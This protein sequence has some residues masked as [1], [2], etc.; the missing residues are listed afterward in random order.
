MKISAQHLFC[1]PSRAWT[2]A[3]RTLRLFPSWASQTHAPAARLMAFL[4]CNALLFAVAR[5]APDYTFSTLA[6]QVGTNGSANGTGSNAQFNQPGGV[7]VD[8]TGT[9]YVADSANHTIRAIS[10]DGVV[11]TLAG[12]AGISGTNDDTGVAAR[13]SFPQGLA[14]D[15][16]GNLFVADTGNN[17][18]RKITPDGIVTT[19]AG[20]AG[21]SGTNDGPGLAAHFLHP[22]AVTVDGAGNVFV[23]DTGNYTIRKITPAGDVTTLAGRPGVHGRTDGPGNLARFFSP[24][25][26]VAD[27]AGNL[28]VADTDNSVIRQIDLA[29]NVGTFAGSTEPGQLDGHGTAAS[30]SQPYGL[31]RDGAGNLY[32]ADTGNG[33]IRRI[34]PAADVA[35][36]PGA[37]NI[38]GGVLPQA[39]AVDL[40]GNVLMADTGNHVIRRGVLTGGAL[41]IVQANIALGGTV[42]GSG[43]YPLGSNVLIT[44]TASNAWVFSAWNDS[45]TNN[46]RMVV[47]PSGGAT[48]TA[49]FSPLGTVTV[50]ANPSTGGSVAGGGQYIMGSNA[51]VTATASN[52]WQFLNWNG[53]MTNNPWSF[54]VSSSSQSCTANFAR[55]S[56]VAVLAS[57]TNGGSVAG[58]GAYVVGS[59]AVLTA[60]ASNNWLFIKWTDGV[61]NNP[62]VIVVPANNSTYTANFAATAAINVGANTNDGGSVTGGGVYLVGSND[63]LTATASNGW[64][65]IRWSDGPTNSPRTVVVGGAGASYTAIFAPT[66]V[67]SVQA[68]PANGG[69][70]TGGGTYVAGS[71]AVLS[72]TASNLWRFISWDDSVTNTPRT[73]VV[74]S[75]GATYTANFSPLGTVTVLANPTS[76]GRVNGGGQYLVG[77]NATVTAT[78]SNNWVFMNWNG[79]VTNNPWLFSVASGSATCT[80]NFAKLSTVTVVASPAGVGSVTGGGSYL[81]GSNVTLTATAA[82]GWL[83]AQWNDGLTNAG[84]VIVVPVANVTYTA[85]FVRGIG[86]AVDATNLTWTTGG[87]ANW[88]VQTATTRDGVAALRSGALSAGQQ[89]WFQTTTNGP[90]SLQFW[91]KV[92]SA[93]TS[94]LQFYINTQLVSQ[95]SG[96]VDWNQVVTFIGT[97]NQVT[98]KWVYTKNTSAVSGSD[99]GWVDQVTWMPCPYA[100]HAPQMFYQDPSGLLASWV[101]D[102]TGGF[103]FA[104]VLANTGGWALKAAG[105]IDGDGVS[106]LLFQDGSGNTGGWFMNPDGSVRDARFWFNIG[107]WEIKACGDYEGTGHGQ[108]FFQT[109]A[110]DVAF[111]RLDTNGV[112]QSSV[113]MGKMV[114]WKLR[115]I[116]DLDGDHKAELFWQNAAGQVAIW[117]HNP[118]GSIRGTSPF[119][120]SVWVLCGVTDIDGDGVSD[121]LWQTPGGDTGGWFMNSNSTQRTAN[122]WWNTGAWR[123]KAAGK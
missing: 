16:I 20:M 6:G 89:T 65:F 77:S 60:M 7:A 63:V 42:S 101:L 96:N 109:A 92:S 116:G 21:V 44:A 81:S 56:T 40:T 51:M 99:A 13:F 117:Y 4:A 95:I 70:V 113:P 107:P 5:G 88:A 106:D 53:S 3:S 84:R 93:A 31:A 15:S 82:P 119:N 23:A 41:L 100:E 43:L 74:P 120:T 27:S 72:A 79:S 38:V 62:R 90:A 18:I 22:S 29:G 37:T 47:V 59:N 67:I 85:T 24:S 57:P 111:W 108:L 66:A 8:G 10:P 69:G 12:S 17:A 118:D 32:V 14:L 34:S 68:N 58:A 83:F 91:W 64:R 52:S 115:G 121:L 28:W 61:T 11:T 48:Y 19:L 2:C 102:S 46:P 114:G 39:V 104:R 49:S 87:N 55:L 80:A 45:V 73:V 122:F 110:G 105:D 9:V 75:G 36:P 123:L 25:G 30:F 98:L 71:N 78:A 94:T 97:S 86:A 54:V 76:G 33:T 50:V 112:Y 35:T 26:I 1:G 103:R